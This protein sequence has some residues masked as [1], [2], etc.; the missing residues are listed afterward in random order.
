MTGPSCGKAVEICGKVTGPDGT[1]YFNRGLAGSTGTRQTPV[2]VAG[3]QGTRLF[4]GSFRD[5]SND[6]V[7]RLA[8]FRLPLDAS[9]KCAAGQT[10]RG[11]YIVSRLVIRSPLDQPDAALVV[12][13]HRRD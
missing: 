5:L 8:D 12:R 9:G 6:H 13:L 2:E 11:G 7:E 3:T 1:R 10:K 4:D